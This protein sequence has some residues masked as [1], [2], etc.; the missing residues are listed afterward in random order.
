[1][2]ISNQA[3]AR[4]VVT[5]VVIGALALFGVVALA[6]LQTDEFPDVNPPVISVSV[7]SVGASPENV[8]REVIV[9]LEDAFRAINGV[10][11]INA[12]ALDGF[13][14]I[15]VTFTF[16]KDLQEASQDI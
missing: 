6:S 1:M 2:F 7:P 13:A 10:D 15:V 4:P 12:R 9:P 8:E 16:D 3:I 5:V 11:E 14:N